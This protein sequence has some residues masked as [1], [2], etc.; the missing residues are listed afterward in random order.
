[1]IEQAEALGEPPEDP[2]LL[3]S[4]LYGFWVASYVGFDGEVMRNLAAQFLS[5]AQKQPARIPLMIGHRIMGISRLCT[6]DTRQGR[7]NSIRRWRFTI[8]PGTVRWR[9]DLP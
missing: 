7:G 9:R 4:V 6:G 8:L 3:F 1:L 2:L 5:L